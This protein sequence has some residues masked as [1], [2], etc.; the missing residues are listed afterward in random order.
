MIIKG[1]SNGKRI[2]SRVLEKTIQEKI[3]NGANHLEVKAQ[4][5]QGIGGRIWSNSDPV[6]IKVS[7]PVGQR[8]GAMGTPGTSIIVDGSASDDVGWLNCGANITVLGD[9]TNGAHNAGAQGILYVQGSGGARCDTMTKQN[10]RFEPL[11]SWYFRNV[12]DSFA[13]F[14]AG[15]IAVIC[16]IDPR[17]QDNVLG[18]RPCV[19]M[20]G[21]IIYVRG[22]VSGFPEHDVKLEPLNESDWQWL[23]SNIKPY[24]QAIKRT[25]HLKTLTKNQDDWQKIVPLTPV[26]K[27]EK[28]KKEYS[29]KQFRRQTWEKEIGKGGIFGDML[30]HTPF[31][32]LPYV[33]TGKN[34]LQTP[35]WH[36]EVK[37]PPC[38]G[39]CPADIPSELRFTL[40]RQDKWHEAMN[41]TFAYTPFPASV[42][43]AV[44]P[45]MCMKACT[46]SLIDKP[47]DMKS[48]G[49]MSEN[50]SAPQKQ[51]DSG[52]KVAVIGGGIAGL[53]AAWHLSLAGHNVDIFEAENRL[54]GKLWSQIDSDKLTR[55][56]LQ[57]EVKRIK[58]T[59]INIIPSTLVKITEFEKI[60]AD[61]DG[62]IISCGLN[63]KEGHGLRFLT[64]DIQCANGKIEVDQVGRTSNPKIF[65]AGDVISRG[66]APHAIGQATRAAKALD[67][68]LKGTHYEV[69]T[70][71]TIQTSQ[72]QIDYY[73]AGPSP[74]AGPTDF[75]ASQEATR[76]LSCGM[77][78]DCRVCESSCHQQAIYREEKANGGFAYKVDPERCIGCGFC[79]GV[80]PCG[81]WEMHQ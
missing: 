48:L 47:L 58:N 33:T 9:V 81:I 22:P 5:Q 18:Y 43:G 21:G 7:G 73:P 1:N 29:V 17:D 40:L 30:T 60:V 34:R 45:N 78:R 66:I 44:C 24:L 15:G 49:A 28:A 14:K 32:T 74:K 61:Y 56:T 59:G 53:T 11:Q 41:T 20:V 50:V 4:G 26:E 3:K 52:F 67:S 55:E 79:A 76:C 71:P 23:S 69:T 39:V 46:R 35:V 6:S 77:C 72:I 38:S 57:A 2:S 65:A 25:K 63:K 64:V 19:G 62:V 8:L 36:N 13:E 70:R 75:S 16:G 80:C 27:K 42:C 31:T 51:P 37:A 68:Q 54:G 10:P 12:G